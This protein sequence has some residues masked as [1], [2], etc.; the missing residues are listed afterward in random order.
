MSGAHRLAAI[1]AAEVAACSRPKRANEAGTAR[2]VRG[3]RFPPTGGQLLLW[4]GSPAKISQA[5][6]A[7]STIVIEPKIGVFQHNPSIRD[8][9]LL[10]TS[11]ARRVELTRSKLLSCGFRR[12][13]P[14]IPIGSRPPIERTCSFG[15][16][17]KGLR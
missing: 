17:G 11:V 5:A 16:G 2:A 8:V 9:R 13:R 15:A 10:G 4:A 1:L 3:Q 7:V 14:R 6:S 12:S